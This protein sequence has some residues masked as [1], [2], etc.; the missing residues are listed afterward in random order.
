MEA[1]PEPRDFLLVFT[2]FPDAAK[3]REATRVLV[4][5]GLVACGNLL[6][7]V[8]SIYLWQGERQ[9]SEEVLA[10][11]KT[12]RASYPALETRL[13]ALHPYEVPEIIA[14]ELAAGLPAY[15]EWVAAGTRPP[16]EL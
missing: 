12:G 11:F 4:G 10:L 7:G 1:N 6:P 5:E 3:A 14:V 2:T 15:L 9:E 8:T 13:K 16:L